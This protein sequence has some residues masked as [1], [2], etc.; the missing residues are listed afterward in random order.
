M[1]LIPSASQT[2]GPFFNF[3][4]TTD[5]KLGILAR[6]G[7]EGE[8][9]RLD[10]RVVDG[11]GAPTPG[12]SMI[13][14]W[15]ADA[16][17]RYAHADPDAAMRPD[18]CGFGRLETDA[19]G[20]VRIRDR[21][22]G[23][24]PDGNGG[25]LQAPHINVVIFARGLLKHLYTRVYFAGERGERARTRCWRWCRRNGARRCWRS[26]WRGSRT[27][28]RIEIRLQGDAG[29]RLL[30]RVRS[31]HVHAIDGEP[32]GHRA[33]VAGLLRCERATGDARLRSGPG[34]GGSAIG[35]DSGEAAAAAIAEAANAEGFDTAELARQ[36]LRAGTPAIP[37]V[38]MLTER[39]RARDAKAAG[40][41]HWGATSQDV[42]DTALVL[43]LRP[44]PPGAGG[45]PRACDR[46][47]CGA[48][49]TSTPTP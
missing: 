48:F 32:G 12:D 3:A 2:V 20:V 42:I 46:A 5:P 19:N 4:L 36:S 33:A 10:F 38:R 11:D 6:E 17:G 23:P 31:I 15:Q 44:V 21:Q 41:V 40:F 45:R 22:A 16:Q 26:P 24:R 13:E 7:A 37:L 27:R 29:N 35:G 25:R 49:P 43:L 1:S 9:I 39:V 28:G 34:A 30:R 14:L 8:R 47:G 18:F